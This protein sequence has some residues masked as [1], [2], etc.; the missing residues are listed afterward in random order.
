ME[1]G[2][3][4]ILIIAVLNK[5]NN[6]IS[7]ILWLQFL[8]SGYCKFICTSSDYADLELKMLQIVSDHN[9]L[10]NKVHEFTDT[11]PS[12]ALTELSGSCQDVWLELSHLVAAAKYARSAFM[13]RR[14]SYCS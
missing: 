6:I 8:P 9:A 12:L 10:Q 14:L 7:L 3:G 5:A 11:S 13:F 2:G 4:E 1:R